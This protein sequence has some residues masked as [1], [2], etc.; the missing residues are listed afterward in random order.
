MVMDHC[1]QFRVDKYDYDR[2][3]LW[4]KNGKIF[5]WLVDNVGRTEFAD[6][7]PEDVTWDHNFVYEGTDIV[8]TYRFRLPGDALI[9]ALRWS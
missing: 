6:T 5:Q 3:W 1:V 7:A 2:N 9:F 4:G 8:I